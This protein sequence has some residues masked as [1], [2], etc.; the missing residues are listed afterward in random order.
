MRIAIISDIHGNYSALKAVV[1][2]FDR[3]RPDTIINLG[4]LIFRGP[5]PLECLQLLDQIG[6]LSIRGNT[7]D[8]FLDGVPVPELQPYLDFAVRA[9]GD[10]DLTELARLPFSYVQPL[11]DGELLCVH[12]SPRSNEE[13]LFPWTE[14]DYP[15]IYQTVTARTVA[16]G[17]QHQAFQFRTSS[18]HL[19]LSTGSVGFPF[20]GDPRPAY[21]LVEAEG[22]DLRATSIRVA[23]DQREAL[24]AAE[25]APGYPGLAWLERAVTT[26]RHP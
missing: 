6:A 16:C 18:G 20:D 11:P 3:T 4:D 19:L 7:D 5:Q 13:F 2:D 15:D 24:K 1:R 17:H 21:T 8:F 12:G 26:A 22:A 23:Y 25:D 10:R 9:C 14:R